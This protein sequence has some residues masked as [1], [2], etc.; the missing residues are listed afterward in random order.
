MFPLA[1]VSINI[2]NFSVLYAHVVEG[3]W[4]WGQMASYSKD[5]SAEQDVSVSE[6]EEGW[7]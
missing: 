2:E 6:E 5:K 7:G 3:F 1:G 4:L